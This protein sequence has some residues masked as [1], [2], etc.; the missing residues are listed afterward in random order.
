MNKRQIFGYAA[1]AV[2]L[3]LTVQHTSAYV[4]KTAKWNTTPVPF[5]VNTQNL[6]TAPDGVVAALEV[7]AYSWTN[8]TSAAFSFYYAGSTSSTTVV[9]NSR[10]EVFFRNATNGGAIATTYTY[11]SGGRIID[12]DIVFW[13]ASYTFFTGSSGCSGGFYIEDVATHEFGH[14]LG[15]GHSDV[16]GASMY[17][18]I[19][20]CSTATRS[21]SE[22]DKQ[23]VEAIYPSGPRQHP[24][25]DSDFKSFRRSLVCGRCHP[26][27]HRDSKRHGRGRHRLA[28]VV[29]FGS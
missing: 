29:G 15:L 23:G 10:N 17:P 21:L 14:A 8:Q 9:N 13:D 28:I 7:G 20:Y 19:G 18:T 3:A 16:S 12:T 11:S 27:L 6:D 4:L 24:T 1:L 2:A 5:Y 26:H 25:A 22:D